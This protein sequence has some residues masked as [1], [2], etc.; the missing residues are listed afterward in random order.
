MSSRD[1]LALPGRR[2][3]TSR[4]E[5]LDARKGWIGGS[6]IAAIMGD[7]PYR[8]R[9]DVVLDKLG[10]GKAFYYNKAMWWGTFLEEKNMEAFEKLSGFVC[11]YSQDVYCKGDIGVTL[12]G[13]V[14]D[15]YV[16]DNER[17]VKWYGDPA[18]LAA[19]LPAILELKNSSKTTVAKWGDGPPKY[20]W[21]Q[22]QAGMYVTGLTHAVLVAKVGSAG[23][24][25]YV[26]E[27]D[28]LA[29]EVASAEATKVMNEVRDAR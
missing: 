20:Y 12:D 16:G 1:I 24:N 5:W 29:M 26:I 7:S 4:S 19:G 2:T 11:E 21:W 14:V 22:C 8:T 17:W 15:A 18:E 27:Y 13:L 9:E 23:M 6:D 3:F 10:R 28:E 25:A